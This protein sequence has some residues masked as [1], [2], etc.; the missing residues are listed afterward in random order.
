MTDELKFLA[1]I[2]ALNDPSGFTSVLR[3]IVKLTQVNQHQY[4]RE[5]LNIQ[6]SSIC[7]LAISLKKM[8]TLQTRFW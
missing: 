2:S 3:N 6:A 8:Y 1:S 7:G 5:K 4:I